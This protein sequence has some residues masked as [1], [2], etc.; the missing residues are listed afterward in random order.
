MA[1]DLGV[2]WGP[3]TLHELYTAWQSAGRRD[4]QHTSALL[5]LACNIHR[6]KHTRPYSPDQFNPFETT[7]R[8]ATTGTYPLTTDAVEMLRVF[9]PAT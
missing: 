4:W 5:S 1:G 3:W 8:R 6:G 2:Y 7:Q 9:L